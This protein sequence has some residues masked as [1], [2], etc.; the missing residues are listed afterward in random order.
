MNDTPKLH[1]M[2]TYMYTWNQKEG[3]TKETM[4]R[5]DKRGLRRTAYGT[6]RGH[7]RDARQESVESNHR[8]AAGACN[9]IAWAIKGKE[10]AIYRVSIDEKFIR[11]ICIRINL[12]FA[13]T[14]IAILTV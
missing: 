7:I 8:R 9:G 1:T 12:I 2:A 13:I 14:P 11:N 6:S 3:K 4:D 5:H 10:E